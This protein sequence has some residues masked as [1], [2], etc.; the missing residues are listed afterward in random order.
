MIPK[1]IGENLMRHN[2]R[3][4]IKLTVGSTETAKEAVNLSNLFIE[5][6]SRAM[7]KVRPEHHFVEIQIP[8]N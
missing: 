3:L 5:N 8:W 4:R 6:D 1:T 2:S 7:G